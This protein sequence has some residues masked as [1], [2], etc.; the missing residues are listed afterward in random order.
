MA[1]WGR[2]PI[3]DG[4]VSTTGTGSGSMYRMTGLVIVTMA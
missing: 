4:T 2:T 3:C 1:I